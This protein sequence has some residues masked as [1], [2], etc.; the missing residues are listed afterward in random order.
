VLGDS[1]LQVL[2]EEAMRSFCR[3]FDV[4]FHYHMYDASEELAICHGAAGTLA[5]ADAFARHAGMSDAAALRDDLARYL[6][7][8]V[9]QLADIART[10]MTMLG[11]AGG[12]LAVLLTAH[13]GTRSWLSLIALR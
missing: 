12:I 8:R 2:G 6:L 10:D 7:E 4:D 1:A 9:D 11:G 3:V 13:G 5:V